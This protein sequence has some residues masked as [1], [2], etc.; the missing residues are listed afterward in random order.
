MVANSLLHTFVSGVADGGDA[1]LVRPSNWNDQHTVLLTTLADTDADTKIQV[2]EAADE[3]KVRMDIAGTERFVL[4]AS[5]PHLNVTGNLRATELQVASSLGF[6]LNPAGDGVEVLGSG[7]LEFNTRSAPAAP[8]DGGKVYALSISGVGFPYHLNHV[9]QAASMLGGYLGNCFGQGEFGAAESTDGTIERYGLW[10]GSATLTGTPTYFQEDAEGFYTHFVSGAVSGNDC[11][12]QIGATGA[13]YH[14]RRWDS[15]VRIKFRLPITTSVRAFVGLSDASLATT[16]GSDDP[17][18]NCLGYKFST[19][20][21]DT[22]WQVYR[23]D[24]TAG[25]TFTNSGV[26]PSATEEYTVL[27]FAIASV[28]AFVA[29]LY[30]AAFTQRHAMTVISNPPTAAARLSVIVGA[31]TQTAAAREIDFYYARG[32]N[33]KI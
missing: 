7:Y 31:E 15:V 4:Q 22:T 8:G 25:G 10:A 17:T 1:T 23:N 33:P 24:G 21:G 26:T 11:G 9:G 13:G 2:E 18:I 28:N 19:P 6:T 14:E 29:A 20:R 5:D 12:I 3:D 27:I 30:D 32:A 16:I